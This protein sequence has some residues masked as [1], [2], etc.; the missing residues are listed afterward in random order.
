[1]DSPHRRQ[2]DGNGDAHTKGD[3]MT[4]LMANTI[5]GCRM[6]FDGHMFVL[7]KVSDGSMQICSAASLLIRPERIGD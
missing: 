5:C 1:M 7:R 4:F 2:L 6:M 3:T